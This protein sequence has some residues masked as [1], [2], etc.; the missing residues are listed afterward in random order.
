MK[1][2]A[3]WAAGGLPTCQSGSV[4]SGSESE[5]GEVC[6]V[7][8]GRADGNHVCITTLQ[9]AAKPSASLGL[10]GAYSHCT[11]GMTDVLK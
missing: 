6:P 11:D 10:L 4:S 1:T 9:S 7:A 2:P 3:P 8:C 5:D